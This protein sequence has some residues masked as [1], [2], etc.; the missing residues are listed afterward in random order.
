VI[1]PIRGKAATRGISCDLD[2]E[3][4]HIFVRALQTAL[5]PKKWGRLGTP[6][7]RAVLLSA[8]SDR[9]TDP[10]IS[11]FGVL[12][13]QPGERRPPAAGIRSALAGWHPLGWIRVF[14]GR[15][16][17]GN[18]LRDGCQAWHRTFLTTGMRAERSS[19]R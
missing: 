15:W 12:Y 11:R 8:N 14:Q 17:R 4:V 18:S 5:A 1:A 16:R 2:G 7:S 13:P 3:V 6:D 10:P 19:L 9:R